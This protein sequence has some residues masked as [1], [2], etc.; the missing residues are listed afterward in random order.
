[1]KNMTAIPPSYDISSETLEKVRNLVKEDVEGIASIFKALSDPTRV[2]ILRSLELNELCVCVFVEAMNYKYSA[3][4]Y[5]LKLLKEANL[6]DFRRKGSFLIYKLTDL[7][8]KILR[9][10][11]EIKDLL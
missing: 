10:V 6:V 3:L 5:H 9:I 1:M 8:G 7:G 11:D 4:S 2:N